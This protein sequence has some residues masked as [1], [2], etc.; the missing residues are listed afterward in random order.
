MLQILKPDYQPTIPMTVAVW[1]LLKA[2][3]PSI[4]KESKAVSIVT[5]IG[6]PAHSAIHTIAGLRARK[7]IRFAVKGNF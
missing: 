4:D 2:F 6:I 7:I 1:A 5:C 3:A